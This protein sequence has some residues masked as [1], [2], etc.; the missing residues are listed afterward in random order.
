MGDYP[1][2]TSLQLCQQGAIVLYIEQ[3]F[4]ADQ[5]GQLVSG[6]HRQVGD[7][8]IRHKIQGLRYRVVQVKGGTGGRYDFLI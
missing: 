2:K 7:V 8:K 6:D 1:G 4:L 3:V 5:S